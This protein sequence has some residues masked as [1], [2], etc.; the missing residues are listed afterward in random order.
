VALSF[1][2]L[3][4][5]VVGWVCFLFFVCVVVAGVLHTHG[6]VWGGF[7]FVFGLFSVV[8]LGVVFRCAKSGLWRT[9][10]VDFM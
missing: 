7:L 3:C 5:D 9:L 6:G 8:F 10:Y 2:V 1:L 4:S